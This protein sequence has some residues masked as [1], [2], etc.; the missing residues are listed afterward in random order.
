MGLE[1]LIQKMMQLLSLREYYKLE[2]FGCA[3]FETIYVIVK[4][5]PYRIL[6]TKCYTPIILHSFPTDTFNVIDYLPVKN[7]IWIFTSKFGN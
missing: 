5:S 3:W 4:S 7:Y 1:R 6:H 2:S